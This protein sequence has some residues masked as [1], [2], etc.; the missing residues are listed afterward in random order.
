MAGNRG[1]LD[2]R[3]S[4]WLGGLGVLGLLLV[5]GLVWLK[6]P[7]TSPAGYDETADGRAEP[8]QVPTLLGTTQ[9]EVRDATN[10]TTPPTSDGDATKDA[11]TKSASPWV[12]EFE[13]VGAQ[14]WWRAVFNPE[15]EDGKFQFVSNA[16]DGPPTGRLE[17]RGSG[18]LEVYAKGC[19]PWMSEVL[20]RPASGTLRVVAPLDEGLSITGTL[21]ASDGSTPVSKGQVRVKSALG[22]DGDP[23][24]NLDR[25][26]VEPDVHGNFRLAGLSPG[27]VVLSAFA[28]DKREG[29]RVQVEAEAGDQR[30][31]IRL[32]PIGI[33]NVL[34]SDAATGK[35]P[36]T[37]S[38]QIDYTSASGSRAMSNMARDPDGEAAPPIQH[39]ISGLKLG[40]PGTLRVRANGYEFFSTEFTF[41]PEG[42]VQDLAVS[43]DR[44]QGGMALLSITL[45][46]DKVPAPEVV[47]VVRY[48]G[49][50]G[51]GAPETVTDGRLELRLAPGTTSLVIGPAGGD[52]FHVPV[53]IEVDEEATSPCARVER[54]VHLVYGGQLRFSE[55]PPTTRVHLSSGNTTV[56][57]WINRVRA[58]D[59]VLVLPPG[60]WSYRIEGRLETWEGEAEI[61]PGKI[62][63]AEWKVERTTK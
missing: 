31:G 13:V 15:S 10:S 48:T 39:R 32:K 46:V 51:V 25:S 9:R 27:P 56:V 2:R 5:L 63:N 43:L 55:R 38:I 50:L 60:R 44:G 22:P 18:R 37:S 20:T 11:V 12:I 61:V 17:V 26:W 19:V 23:E 47:S 33:L 8:R 21:L 54:E 1:N 7:D 29:D 42:G 49:D 41:P 36:Q 35:A 3:T 4:T 40:S 62:T 58:A 28:Y 34:I 59:A 45:V 52:A 24:S 6:G 53:R 30:V 57:R 16:Y 14:R